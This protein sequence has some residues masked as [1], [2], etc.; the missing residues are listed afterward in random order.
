MGA[1][2]RLG[3][4]GFRPSGCATGADLASKVFAPNGQPCEGPAIIHTLINVYKILL[5]ARPPG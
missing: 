2:L 1:A 5:A 3:T 4:D